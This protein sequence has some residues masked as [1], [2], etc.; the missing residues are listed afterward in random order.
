MWQNK[1]QSLQPWKKYW[2]KLVFQSFISSKESNDSFFTFITHSFPPFSPVS[3]LYYR[4][5][6]CTSKSPRKITFK[7]RERE[8]LVLFLEKWILANIFFPR[9]SHLQVANEVLIVS[10]LLLPARFP[11]FPQFQCCITGESLAYQNIPGKQHWNWGRG[12]QLFYFWKSAFWPIYFFQAC[13][14]WAS[15]S[16]FISR[17]TLGS[18]LSTCQDV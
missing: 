7:L 1:D 14:I 8:T 11:P 16:K 10:S 17:P 6:T 13:R 4:L 18:E 2:P 12:G 9:F 15:F 5:I 3:M